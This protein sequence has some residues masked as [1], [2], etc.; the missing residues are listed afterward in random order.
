MISFS[1]VKSV[2]VQVINGQFKGGARGLEEAK[3]KE[4]KEK[5]EKAKNDALLA[6][7]FKNAQLLGGAGEAADGENTKNINM[8]ADPRATTENMPET[9]ITCLHFIEAVENE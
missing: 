5:K 9:I 3:F 2:Q 8:Y 4:M 1:F 7:L 6:S